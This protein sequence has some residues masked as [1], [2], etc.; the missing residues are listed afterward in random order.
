VALV[1]TG[2]ASAGGVALLVR[3][4]VKRARAFKIRAD[5]LTPPRPVLRR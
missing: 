5:S 3:K 4:L 2:G 1:A